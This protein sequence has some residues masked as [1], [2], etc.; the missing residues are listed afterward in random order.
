M[1]DPVEVAVRWLSD[2][3]ELKALVGNRVAEKQRYGTGW[4]TSQAGVMVRLDGGLAQIDVP[5]QTPRFEVRCYAPT[6]LKAMQVWKLLVAISRN[7]NRARVV[8]GDGTALL[9]RFLQGS[10][11]SLLYDTDANMDFVLCFF[12]AAIAEEAV[13]S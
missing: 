10:G 9:Y 2:D 3:A 1:I 7:T 12:E 8:V 4:T 6:P 5:I 13:S 11:P